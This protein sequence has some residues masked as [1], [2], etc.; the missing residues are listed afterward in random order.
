MSRYEISVIIPVYN[1]EKYIKK[2]LDSVLNQK[3]VNAE[4]IIVDDGSTDETL[5]I[6]Q[7][8]S[9][10]NPNIKVIRQGNSGVSAARN[11]ALDNATGDYITFIDSDDWC[12]EDAFSTMLAAIK[13]H[14]VDAVIGES[15]VST[16]DGCVQE[17]IAM[18]ADY[19]KQEIGVN[20]FWELNS[21]K[22]SN[23]LFTV[24]WGKLYKKSVW[25]D[26]R[27]D[28]EA[29][30]AE[31]EY[32][33]PELVERCQKFYLLDQTV[34]VQR[35]SDSSL[36]RSLFDSKKLKSPDSKLK[37]CKHLIE[38]GL[39]DCAVEKWGI[40]VGEIILMTKLAEDTVTKKEIKL[41]HK[42]VCR[43]GMFLFKYM[44]VSKK[45]K[46]IVYYIGYPVI[47]NIKKK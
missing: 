14:N 2:C 19:C 17:H 3:D 33:L 39:Y 45:L 37:T 24:V 42:E 40:A 6:C 36:S 16:D 34:Y 7:E 13:E 22:S 12:A 8:Y 47:S 9:K 10:L 5:H 20:Q 27:F 41:L 15:D 4:I 31:D 35:V 46:F 29:T 38:K 43:L 11:T 44:S 25:D 18:P 26:L 28:T 32:V 23:F 30:F 1:R 21:R